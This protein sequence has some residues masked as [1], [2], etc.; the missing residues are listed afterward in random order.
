MRSLTGS[1]N[2][3]RYLRRVVLGHSQNVLDPSYDYLFDARLGRLLRNRGISRVDELVRALRLNK[4]AALERAVAEAMTINET[5][6]F[7]DHRP[8]EYLRTDL[9]PELI[10]R[11]RA[12]RTLRFWSAACSTGQEA[13]SLAMLLR[14]NFGQIAHWS[15]RIEGT[16]VCAE[17][18]ERAREARYHRIEMNRGLPARMLVR[19]FANAGEHWEAKQ[20]IRAMCHFQQANLCA[21][22]LPFHDRFDVIFLRNVML[23]FAPE[24]RMTLLDDV[25]RLLA[26]DGLLFLGASEQPPDG[27]LWTPVLAGGTCHYKPKGRS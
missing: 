12:V 21:T 22:P 7:R 14:E 2:D 3:Y 8:F 16:D 27:S 24:T 10:E 25:H 20:E 26:P 19:Y 23:Y 6:F 9:L 17:A 11:R 4:D 13:L 1:A 18:V 15:I 5:S